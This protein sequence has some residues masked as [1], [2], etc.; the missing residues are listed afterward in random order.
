MAYY[1]RYSKLRG[2]GLSH[3]VPFV[4]ITPNNSDIMLF[5]EKDKM[6]MDTLSYK[7]YNDANYGWLIMLANPQY[8]SM[9][10]SIPDG[11]PIRIPYPLNTAISRYERSLDDY[12]RNH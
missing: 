10:F 2:D 11:S 12:I 1:D 6:R 5:F 4:S 7:Y 3:I 8:G 9:E